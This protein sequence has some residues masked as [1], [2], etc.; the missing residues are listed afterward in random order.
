MPDLGVV[1]EAHHL[2]DELLAGLVGGVG[3]A[4]DDELD[5]ALLVEQ[6]PLEPGRVAQHQGEPLVGR[7]PAGEPDGQHVGV[8]DVVDPAEL[9]RAGA[10]LLPRRL[11]AATGLLDELLA[12]LALGRPDRVARD[13]ADPVPGVVA[14]DVGGAEVLGGDLVDLAVHPGA[15][16]D[17]VG[18]TGDRHL[19]VVEARPQ[20]VE[21]LAADDAVQLGDA[22]GALAQPQAHHGHVEHAGLAARVVLGAEGE[23]P[24]DRHALDGAVAAEVPGDQVGLEPVDAGRHGRVRGEHGGGADGLEGLVE[25]ESGRLG[26]LVDPLDAEEAGVALVGVVDVRASG[27]R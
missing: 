5:R 1:G 21:H 22:V 16:V 13:V 3:L 9:G 10:A 24:V 14:L 7:H 27:R 19:V 11:G 20:A 8:E 2:L 15:G 23:Q 17:T 25:G 12:H 4:G 18:D 26:Q 6:Q